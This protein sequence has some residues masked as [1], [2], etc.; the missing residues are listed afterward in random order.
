VAAQLVILAFDGAHTADDML[1]LVQDLDDRGLLTI[2]DAVVASRPAVGD[3]LMPTVGTTGAPVGEFANEHP[4]V[5]ITQTDSRRGRSALLGGGVGLLLG[6]LFGGPV[7][8]AAVGA[9]IGALRDRGIDDRFI[10]ELGDQLQ[11]DSSAI[12][13]LVRSAEPARVLEELR[14][15]KGRVIHTTIAPEVEAALRKTLEQES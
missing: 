13:L 9:V 10:H 12:F 2:E 8:G 5:T 15:Y 14:P 4:A 11:P 6:W 1:T 3:R 7:G